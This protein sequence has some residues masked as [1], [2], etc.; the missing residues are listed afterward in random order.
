MI[1]ELEEVF[2]Q[3]NICFMN[4]YDLVE[5]YVGETML[6]YLLEYSLCYDEI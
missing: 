1:K 6:F 3:A 2:F 5:A 4:H